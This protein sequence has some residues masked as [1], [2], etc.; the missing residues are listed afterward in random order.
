MTYRPSGGGTTVGRVDMRELIAREIVSQREQLA[1]LIALEAGPPI[2]ARPVSE[3]E[4]LRL[5]MEEDPAIDVRAEVKKHYQQG[6]QAGKPPEEALEVAREIA[7]NLR[8]PNR[9][10]LI[11]G[12][13]RVT[14][15]ARVAY[16]EKMAERAA[17]RL[18]EQET[19]ALRALEGIESFE[20]ADEPEPPLLV[21]DPPDD[22]QPQALQALEALAATP[23]PQGMIP[24]T[25]PMGNGVASAAAPDDEFRGSNGAGY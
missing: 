3:A 22:P 23:A 9:W 21:E 19:E 5:W 25:A 20:M 13:G 8:Y 6:V 11:Q 14:D 16:A 12:E 1:R 7:A 15:T 4:Q 10:A 17:K 24:P 18:G 2:N